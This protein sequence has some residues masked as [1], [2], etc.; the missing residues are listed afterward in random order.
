F[1]EPAEHYLERIQANS[2]RLLGLI[3][4]FLDLSRIDS[5]QIQVDLLPLAP[6][7]LA[8]RW[9]D[10]LSVLAQKKGIDLDVQVGG[11]VPELLYGDEDHLS[12][13]GVNLLSNAIKFTE[14]G[15]VTLRLASTQDTWS[16]IVTDTGIGIPEAA[17]EFIFDE[18]RQVDGSTRRKYG[19][20][21]LGLAI[22]KK[23]VTIMG[24]H[25]AVQSEI[26]KGSTFTVTLPLKLVEEGE[27]DKIVRD[28]L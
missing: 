3:N 21:G 14:S 24:G 8:Q 19:G 25:I 4:N 9:R 6:V 12:R 18:F 23:L 20:S 1:N 15:S 13:I 27:G 17:R 22:V 5:G 2:R 16:I 7:S 28:T 11:R 10:E 26:G